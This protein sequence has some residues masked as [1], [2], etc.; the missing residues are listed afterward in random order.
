MALSL[1]RHIKKKASHL[2]CNTILYDWSLSGNVPEKFK[3]TPP[4][5]WAGDSNRGRWLCEGAFE[6]AGDQLSANA[7]WEPV[8]VSDIW[9]SHM[10][11]F[12]WLRDLRTLGGDVARRQA[13]GMVG[14]WINTYPRWH[15]LA[16][17]PDILAQRV[18]LWISTYEFFGASAEDEF[19]DFFLQSLIRQAR[20]LQRS[21]PGNLYGV[22]L[23]RGIRGLLY[24]GVV[25][26]GREDWI[27]QALEMLEG[28]L[29]VQILS[30]GGHVSRSPAKLLEALQILIDMRGALAAR[31]Y[32]V[33]PELQ[34]AIDRAVPA[35]RFFRFADKGFAVMNGAQEADT[36]HMDAVL[37]QS[38]VRGRALEGLPASGYE[39]LGLG[40]TTL[41][42]DTGK[43]PPY[44]HDEGAHAAPLA[45]EM[46]CGKDRVFV[47]CGAHPTDKGWQE[48]LRATAAHNTLC[49]DNRNAAEIREDGHISRPVRMPVCVR[50][51]A[52]GAVLVEASHDGYVP[53]NGLTH[54]RRI[55]LSNKG[56]DIRGEDTL[57]SAAPPI[58]PHDVAIRFHLHPRVKV[59][60]IQDGEAALLR[61]PCGSGWRFM[62]DGGALALEDSIYCG[63]GSRPLKTKQLVIYGQTTRDFAQVK[64][65]LSKE[66]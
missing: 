37:A 18:A 34:H 64:W 41:M 52:K 32:P 50:E 63:Q 58:K 56:N 30:D 66:G 8:G 48:A 29:P 13:R 43:T 11:G 19:Q 9:L 17:R 42:I 33:P 49:L 51:E 10:H 38:G 28:Q 22:S 16:W 1:I 59:S 15:E 35:L 6:I 55:Y 60:L 5:P 61:L 54:R 45:C 23:L 47:S 20:H 39:R 12:S 53:L 27:E 7:C 21:L 62:H 36:L 25:F 3:L 24:A 26:E 44:P 65:G 40:R 31:G 14:H 4:D 57:C 2:A 46:T